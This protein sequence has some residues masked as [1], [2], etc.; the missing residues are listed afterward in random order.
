MVLASVTLPKLP[1][2][3]GSDQEFAVAVNDSLGL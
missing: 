2:Y 3:F 1:N